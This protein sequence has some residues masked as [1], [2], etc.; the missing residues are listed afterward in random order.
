MEFDQKEER[1]FNLP[2]KKETDK[3]RSPSILQQASSLLAL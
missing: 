1:P 2:V 3:K